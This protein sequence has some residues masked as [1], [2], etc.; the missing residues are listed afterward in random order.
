MRMAK[1]HAHGTL[2]VL[3]LALAGCQQQA[4][5][6]V[7]QTAS[8]PE[9]VMVEEPVPEPEQASAIDLKADAF[10]ELASRSVVLVRNPQVGWLGSGVEIAPGIFVTNCHVLEGGAQYQI[11]REGKSFP[12]RLMR[13][14]QERDTCLLHVISP[15]SYPVRTRSV[16][17]VKVG[18][19]V[20][21]LGNPQGL[22]LTLSEGIVSQ[23]RDSGGEAPLIQ[24]TAAI[25]Q[26]SSGG[27]LFDRAGNLI[28]IPTFMYREGQN[29]NF[30]VPVDWA[31]ELLADA[32]S[33]ASQL[34]APQQQARTAAPADTAA[35]ARALNE[36]GIALSREQRFEEA[37]NVFYEAAKLADEDAEIVGNFGYALLMTGDYQQAE[38]VLTYALELSPNRASTWFNLGQV[39][40]ETGATEH[41]V[42]S[43]E[44]AWHHSSRKHAFEA[45]LRSEFNDPN[46]SLAWRQVVAEAIRRIQQ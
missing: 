31:L 41:A 6:P 8:L 18:E 46:S 34:Q 12:A 22:A 33:G 30:A 1:L 35:H 26:G 21:A 37:A 32:S 17:S 29:L 43:V 5:P 38:K 3:A 23:L 4:S 44:R 42:R 24:T 14:A 11:E 19:G 13:A 20:Y 10:Y 27:G 28:A 40:A 15:E 7:A 16:L 25:S 39:Q 2:A 45:S 9:P 36:R